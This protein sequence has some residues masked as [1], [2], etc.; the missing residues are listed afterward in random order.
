MAGNSS[1]THVVAYRLPNDVYET[2]IRR[3]NKNRYLT[4]SAYLKARTIYDT[5]RK[6]GTETKA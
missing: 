6:H 5:R 2:L 3:C 4:P 1:K